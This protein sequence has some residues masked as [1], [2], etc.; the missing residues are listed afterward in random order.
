MGAF[1]AGPVARDVVSVSDSDADGV[2]E[3]GVLLFDPVAGAFSVV[4]RD[5]ADG[6]VTGEYPIP[7]AYEAV[8]LEVTPSGDVAV[9]LR[10]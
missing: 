2:D 9:L 8:D 10:P 1:E 5:E 7:A 3:V 4:L 6:T